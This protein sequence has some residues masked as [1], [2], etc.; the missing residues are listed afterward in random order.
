MTP[1][2]EAVATLVQQARRGLLPAE[3]E[4]CRRFAP[5]VRAFARRRLRSVEAVEESAKDGALACLARRTVAL[6]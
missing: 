6:R 3:S 4:L 2:V 5:A 1:T